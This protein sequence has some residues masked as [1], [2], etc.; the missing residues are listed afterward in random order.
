[1]AAREDLDG[2]QARKLFAARCATGDW[3]A[4]VMTHSAFT[5]IP[6][7]PATEA[8]HLTDLA[9]RYRQALTAEPG[10]GRRTVKQLAK[11]IDTFETRA[12]TLLDHRTDDGVYFEHLGA[13]F[14]L[15]DE[16]HY[17]KNLGI[18][19]RTDG[20]S[21]AASKRATDL[22]MKLALLRER[23]G[24]TA[25]LFTGTPVSNSLLEMYVLQ[26]Y[27]HPERLAEVGLHSADAWAA[28]FVDFQ[29]S[30]E[31]T[32]D[33]ASF[34][35]KRRPAKFENVPELLT[36]FGEV[37]DLRQPESF[38]VQRPAARHHNVVISSSPQLRAYVAEPRGASRPGSPGRRARGQHAEDLQ[39]RPQSRPRSGACR[40]HGSRARQSRRGRRQCGPHLP[41]QPLTGPAR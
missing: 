18:P 14:L 1:M 36:L 26:H 37:A 2:A 41:C 7:H 5:A 19:V 40:H 28:T 23:G 9:A 25:A 27:L 15:V 8:A 20:F 16:S 34:R 32:P 12:R 35:M 13:D 29:T 24:K 3:D 33:G 6:V 30:V 4:V 21:V 38:A 39:R 11:M 31:V 22:D 10:G 17:F